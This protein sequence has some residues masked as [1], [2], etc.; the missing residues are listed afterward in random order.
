M[1]STPTSSTG[2]TYTTHTDWA[3]TGEGQ[4]HKDVMYRE[5]EENEGE[6]LQLKVKQS[7]KSPLINQPPSRTPLVAG[8]I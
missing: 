1:K 3:G 5:T 4:E 7:Q 2:P 8:G 6:D